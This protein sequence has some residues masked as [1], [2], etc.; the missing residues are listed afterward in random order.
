LT[1]KLTAELRGGCIRESKELNTLNV[2]GGI[3]GRINVGPVLIGIRSV[4]DIAYN[5]R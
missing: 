3:K 2:G 4:L 1:D 5:I